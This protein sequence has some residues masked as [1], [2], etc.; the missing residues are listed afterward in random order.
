[1]VGEILD[2][3]KDLF[4]MAEFTPRGS[5][6]ERP[7]QR[8]A[9]CQALTLHPLRSVA[10]GQSIYV[11][12]DTSRARLCRTPICAKSFPIVTAVPSSFSEQL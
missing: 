6:I 8:S 7:V 3:L 5:A 4:L 9:F 11:A 10:T 2:G 1:M 12:T